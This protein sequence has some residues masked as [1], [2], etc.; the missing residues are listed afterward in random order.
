MVIPSDEP[1][2]GISLTAFPGRAR[3]VSELE[4][5]SDQDAHPVLPAKAYPLPRKG[6]PQDALFAV[7]TVEPRAGH[8]FASSARCFTR[9]VK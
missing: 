3:L 4:R 1:K 7:S 5:A 2:R 6:Y 9:A 8:L